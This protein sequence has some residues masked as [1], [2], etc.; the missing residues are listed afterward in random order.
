M[1]LS[2][3]RKIGKIYSLL[4]EKHLTSENDRPGLQL[5]EI[6]AT[7]DRL[8]ILVSAIPTGGAGTCRVLAS[9]LIAQ[10]DSPDQGPPDIVD[11]QV[12][13]GGRVELIGQIS[14]WVKGVGKVS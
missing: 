1:R 12:H 2:R 4:D 13:V 9:L 11:C 10:I 8:A 7:G 6:H 14:V 3:I 5:I